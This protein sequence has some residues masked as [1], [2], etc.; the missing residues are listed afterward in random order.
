[1]TLCTRSNLTW[2]A[3]PLLVAAHL[4]LGGAG[5]SYA[6]AR[7]EALTPEGEAANMP[8]VEERLQVRIEGQYATTTMRHTYL[9]KSEEV[10]EGRYQIQVG[11]GSRVQGFAYWNG[12]TKIVGDVYE[13]EIAERVYEEVTGL[14]RDPGLLQQVGEGAFSFRVFPIARR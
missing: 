2:W 7:F 6:Q 9:N 11:E 1:M 3:A 13:K 4:T 12:E 10:L 5:P 14:G 8:L